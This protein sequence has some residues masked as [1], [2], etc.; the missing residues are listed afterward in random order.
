[1]GSAPFT[2]TGAHVPAVVAPAHDMHV[3]AQAVRQQ[4]PCA[5]TPVVHSVPSLHVPP[6]DLRPHDPALHT[7]GATQSA[8]AVQVALHEEA[9]HLYGAHDVDGG[10]THAPA[11]S[12]LEAGVCVVPFAG[13]LAPPHGVPC[14]YFWQAPASHMPFVPHIEGDWATHV[15]VGSGE[16]VATALHWPMVP[17]SAHERQVPAQAVAQHTPCA[18]KPEPHSSAFEQKAPVGFFPHDWLAHVFGATQL[19]LSWHDV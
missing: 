15:P 3:P 8:S 5:Q 7:D 2:G 11:P 1:M 9:P 6:G 19:P 18:Q 12:Q 4:T 13:Q 17:P 16:P 14:A 10:V